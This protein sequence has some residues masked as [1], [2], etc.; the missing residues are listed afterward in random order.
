MPILPVLY[1]RKNGRAR[2]DPTKKAYV[3]YRIDVV[4]RGK[5]HRDGGFSSRK[6]AEHFVDRLKS[7]ARDR[8]NGLAAHG[9]AP[10][11]SELLRKR[12]AKIAHPRVKTLAA[13]VFSSFQDLLDTDLPITDIRSGHFQMYVNSRKVGSASIRRELAEL[14]T[15]FRSA[16][17]IFPELDYYSP[18]VIKRPRKGKA[19][20][21]HVVTREEKDAIVA[22]LQ[23]TEYQKRIGRMFAVA[24]FLGLR[25]SEVIRLKKTDLR[26][27]KL[28]TWRLKTDDVT[29]FEELPKEL[30]QILKAAIKASDS[31]YIFPSAQIY[32]NSFYTELKKAVEAAGLIYGRKLDGVTFHSARHS[33]VTRAMALADIKTVGSLSGH[34]DATM[35]M[36]YTHATAE[37]RKELMRKMYGK[38]EELRKTYDKIRA[39]KM[40]FE[41][42]KKV[43]G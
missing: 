39:G 7:D 14:S 21:K 1:K 5:R 25:Y 26:G 2:Y 32:P 8:R 3:G 33:F 11:V 18:P 30:I 36:H 16:S 41:E 35:V 34:A 40:T 13:R 38:D 12:L 31:E 24:W 42:F 37:S 29:L 22:H 10:R 17:E 27:S 15:A 43:V 20:T 6:E 9:H 23:N 28:T 19:A 4:V